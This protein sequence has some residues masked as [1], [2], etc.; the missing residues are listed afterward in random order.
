MSLDSKRDGTVFLNELVGANGH[1]LELINPPNLLH[2]LRCNYY[3]HG[4][5]TKAI[6]LKMG[7]FKHLNHLIESD[8]VG[9]TYNESDK[10]RNRCIFSQTELAARITGSEH[11]KPEQ[12][13]IKEF[14]P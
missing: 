3:L 1:S 11:I 8:A 14:W 5:Q 7:L 6:K 13:L 12:E 10:S 4:P 2:T 9:M